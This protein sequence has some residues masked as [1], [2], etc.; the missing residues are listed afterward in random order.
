MLFNRISFTKNSHGLFKVNCEYELAPYPMSLFDELGMHK[1]KKFMMYEVFTPLSDPGIVGNAVCVIYGGFLIH[2]VLWEKGEI[3][4]LILN[5]YTEHIKNPYKRNT[6][7]VFDGY[8]GNLT[9]K[10]KQ[11]AER[12][13]LMICSTRDI[14][15]GGTIPA[16][17]RQ[18]K[19]LSNERNKSRF[20][21]MLIT[22]LIN[23]AVTVKQ[24]TE[25]AVTLIVATATEDSTKT[26]SVTIVGK[27]VDLLIIL[28]ALGGSNMN[29][30]ILKRKYEIKLYKLTSKKFVSSPRTMFFSYRH[31]VE[32]LLLLPFS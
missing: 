5:K 23:K 17:K 8:P 12:A 9:E 32:L 13:R 6:I 19:F 25:D 2:L 1:T 31:L 16:T 20:I 29:I 26:E 10:R 27:D 24:A 28:T 18:S 7:V 22:R 30:Y 15:F 14:M 21:T 11:C 4:L 3:C